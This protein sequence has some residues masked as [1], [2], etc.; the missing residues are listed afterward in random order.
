MRLGEA[1]I[2]REELKGLVSEGI[3]PNQ[4]KRGQEAKEA[5]LAS[6]TFELVAREWY[7]HWKDSVSERHASYTINRLEKD[8][9]PTLGSVPLTSI[10]APMVLQVLRKVEGRN[11]VEIAHRLKQ[12][13][14]MVMRYGVHTGR[15]ASD[16]T[17][18]LQGALKSRPQGHYPSISIDE[19]PELLKAM[20]DPQ[21]RLFPPTRYALHLMLHTFVRTGELMGAK[22]EEFNLEK[23]IWVIPATRMKMKR[24]H[25]VPIST[26]SLA[27]LEGI[28]Q[29]N[30]HS[31]LLFPNM[32]GGDGHMSTE[33]LNR[34]LELM[35]YKG[36]MSGHGFRPLATGILTER[37]GYSYDLVDLQL[38]HSKAKVRAAYDRAQHLPQ[39]QAMMQAYSDYIEGQ[40]KTI[41][42]VF[43]QKAC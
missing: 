16:P 22:W 10:S 39:R 6:T 14:G 9:F 13:I 8:V 12:A 19:L 25:I 38:A 11:A 17:R 4:L 2:K 23:A 3:D 20:S 32:R 34:A 33:S 24:Q 29:L 5:L 40:I 15:I 31:P 43:I 27:I 18:D 37:L 7:D 35:G 36:R 28:R 42:A 26:Q 30:H 21:Y 41:E 1:R